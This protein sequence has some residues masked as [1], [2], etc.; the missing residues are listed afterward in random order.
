MS[1]MFVLADLANHNH[2][3]F[4]RRAFPDAPVQPYTEPSRRIRRFVRWAHL[5]V[6]RPKRTS[7]AVAPARTPSYS[8]SV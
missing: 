8:H 6:Q 5:P 3:D 1:P 7:P 4:A 2:S